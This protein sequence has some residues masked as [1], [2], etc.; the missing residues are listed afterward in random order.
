MNTTPAQQQ[1]LLQL[2]TRQVAYMIAEGYAYLEL[3]P[4]GDTR[5]VM[6]DEASLQSEI[7]NVK[8]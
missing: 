3:L 1:Q 6:H 8:N 2:F 4:S 7:N 5:L